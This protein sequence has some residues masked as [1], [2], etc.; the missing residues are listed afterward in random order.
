MPKSRQ[1]MVIRKP[2]QVENT[3]LI[4]VS[5]CVCV[6]VCLTCLTGHLQVA[7]VSSDRPPV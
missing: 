6:C 7:V 3:Y 2:M 4:D 5:S 1:S